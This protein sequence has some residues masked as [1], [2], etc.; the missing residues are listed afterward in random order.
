MYV[1]CSSSIGELTLFMS[2]F[3]LLLIQVPFDNFVRTNSGEMSTDQIGMYREK[4]RS[5]GISLLGGNSGAGGPYELG[6]DS[7]RIVNDEDVVRTPPG[8]LDASGSCHKCLNPCCCRGNTSAHL[9]HSNA[10][11][12]TSPV[13]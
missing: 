12:V 13:E 11:R 8:M 9:D 1:L 7:I 2:A 6:I 10:L 5:I 3:I 4:V